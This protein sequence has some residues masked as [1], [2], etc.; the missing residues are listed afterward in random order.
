MHHAKVVD[1]ISFEGNPFSSGSESEWDM[2]N[3]TWESS[4]AVA[5][6]K[7]LDAVTHV[8]VIRWQCEFS[9]GPFCRPIDYI[10]RLHGLEVGRQHSV[11]FVR[12]S[13]GRYPTPEP[14]VRDPRQTFAPVVLNLEIDGDHK[15]YCC[16][17]YDYEHKGNTRR[18]PDYVA[19]E[20]P[21]LKIPDISAFLPAEGQP[22]SVPHGQPHLTVI[23]HRYRAHR[24]MELARFFIRGIQR[25]HRQGLKVWIVGLEQMLS[26]WRSGGGG[27]GDY[28]L[29]R[30]SPFDPKPTSPG[31]M[32]RRTTPSS[33]T[34][35]I[36]S[37][38]AT[39]SSSSSSPSFPATRGHTE[40][41]SA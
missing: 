37:P 18:Q 6:T 28:E 31:L 7:L 15:G 30:S 32:S 17:D 14:R 34:R 39:I 40:P 33:P 27:H 11:Y 12:M 10:P 1:F 23:I 2:R 20:T 36:A 19:G 21:L 3:S 22:K 13:C 35:S 25:Q 8:P 5:L 24:A 26:P 38:S 9:D 16:C 4:S 41:T 29:G